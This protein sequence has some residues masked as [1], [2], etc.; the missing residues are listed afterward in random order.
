[1]LEFE[2]DPAPGA[3]SS[4]LHCGEVNI[5]EDKVMRVSVAEADIKQ[6]PHELPSTADHGTF[7][8]Q[9]DVSVGW[10]EVGGTFCRHIM[11]AITP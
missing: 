5:Y 11:S 8:K 4:S 10:P 3:S 1:M 9:A 7:C 6:N 2:T